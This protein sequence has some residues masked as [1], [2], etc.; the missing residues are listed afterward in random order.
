MQRQANANVMMAGISMMSDAKIAHQLLAVKSAN[1]PLIASS[2]IQAIIGSLMVMV[3]V[4]VLLDSGEMAILAN[5]VTEKLTS[6]M[7]VNKTAHAKSARIKE[8]STLQPNNATAKTKP[9]QNLIQHNAYHVT[10]L[11][12][13]FIVRP[14]ENIPAFSV[15]LPLTLKNNQ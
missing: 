9:T 4:F 12:N 2:V 8:S 13:A 14:L 11:D 3:T 15:T 10:L 5:P 1:Q 7:N 6:V